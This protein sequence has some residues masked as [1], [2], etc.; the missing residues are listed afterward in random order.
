LKLLIENRIDL[1]RTWYF[2]VLMLD[3]VY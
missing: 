3:I 2:K 1:N